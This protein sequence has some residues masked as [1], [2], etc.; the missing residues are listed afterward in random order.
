[1][2]GMVE[3]WKKFCPEGI[4]SEL[5]GLIPGANH[6]VEGGEE[7]GGERWLADRVVRFLEGI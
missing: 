5:S 3:R 6:R 7:E 4:A 2:E 1:M